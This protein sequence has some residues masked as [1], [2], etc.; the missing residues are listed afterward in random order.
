MACASHANKQTVSV[1][2]TDDQIVAQITLTI[3]DKEVAVSNSSSLSYNWNTR[4]RGR[5]ENSTHTVT[6]QVSDQAGNSASKTIT[7]YN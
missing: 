5:S 7:V 2:A 4:K 3:N 6:V 1:S